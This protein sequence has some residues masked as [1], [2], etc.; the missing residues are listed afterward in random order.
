M[1][2]AELVPYLIQVGAIVPR[3]LPAASPPFHCNHNPNASC[4]FDARYIRHSTEDYWALKKRI[5]ELIDQ[6]ILSFSKEKPNVKTNPLPNHGGPTVNTVIE[7]ETTES[8]LRADDVKTPLSVALKR[9]EMFGF[10]VGIHDDCTVC[11]HD[12]DNFDKL[13][14]YV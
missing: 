3:K 13:R 14:G 6:E 1:P 2:Y 12:P 4:A 5:Q 7:E 8:V 10:L 9:L 11:E